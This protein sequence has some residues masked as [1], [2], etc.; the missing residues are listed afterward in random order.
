MAWIE[1]HQ[2]LARHIKTKRL[3]RKL[4]ISVPA[5]IGHLHLLWWWSLD[6][7]PNGNLSQL[8]PE[9]IADEMM[10]NGD[11][12]VLVRG[13]MESGF[14]DEV[15][16]ELFIHDFNDYVG[17]LVDKRKADAVR[18]RTKRSESKGSKSEVLEM[19]GGQGADD[20]RDGAGNS[21]VPN[22]TVQ[23]EVTTGESHLIIMNLYCSLHDKL[24]LHIKPHDREQ[25]MDLACSGIPLEF[26]LETMQKLFENKESKGEKIRGFGYYPP[27]IKDAWTNSSTPIISERRTSIP[28]WKKKTNAELEYRDREIQFNRWVSAGN[29]PSEFFYN[30]DTKH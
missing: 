10:W 22:S 14:V 19:S 12:H 21:T 2:G 7:T 23:K 24:D 29:D 18:K 3:S 26:I 11:P 15:E 9:D 28:D 8:E 16:G 1:S 20:P 13:L 5:A 25:M 30:T 17:K 4:D 6:N 27:V